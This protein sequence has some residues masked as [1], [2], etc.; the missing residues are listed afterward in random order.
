MK[1]Y[2]CFRASAGLLRLESRRVKPGEY[3]LFHPVTLFDVSIFEILFFC[4]FFLS[5]FLEGVEVV[6]NKCLSPFKKDVPSILFWSLND[7]SKE[8]IEQDANF[9]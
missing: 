9:L 5:Q 8:D 7:F 3:L 6:T 1:V 4:N 2:C